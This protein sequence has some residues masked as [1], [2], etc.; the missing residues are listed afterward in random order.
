MRFSFCRICTGVISDRSGGAITTATVTA[1]NDATGVISTTSTNAEGAYRFGNLPVGSYTL[2]ASA[3]G[4]TTA[5]V[6]NFRVQLSTVLTANI[7]LDV[8]TTAT[9]VEV[10]AA[11]AAIDTTTA[12]LQT[13]FETRQT[14]ELP[15]ASSG[16]G[17][18]N[19]SLIGA[20]VASQG[21]VGQGTGP[22]IAGQRPEDNTF[23]LD[24]VSNVNHYSTGPL[25]YVSN[26][27]VAEVSLLQ[28]Q[29]SPEFGGGSGGVFN[30]VV[31]SGTN[32]IHGSI[33]EY[34]QNRNL[35]AV[36]A[37]DWTQGLT[38]LRQP[39][40]RRQLVWIHRQPQRPDSG[41]C[42][43]RPL[44]R[45]LHQQLPHHSVDGSLYLLAT[46]HSKRYKRRHPATDSAAVFCVH[47]RGAGTRA[48]HG[49]TRRGAF[50]GGSVPG[51]V[52][53]R[54]ARVPAPHWS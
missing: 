40:E 2:T 15:S 20:G 45:V 36:D 46:V 18:W 52:P 43:I 24:G 12:Q 17:I 10:S 31:K 8:G 3:K 39:C 30:A 9:S 23:N 19:L 13:T 41:Q 44:R 21:G 35:N 38:S 16:A 32:S 28:N 53:A 1:Q 6:K 11:A 48:C 33:Y 54:Q 37:L 51:R 34:L 50:S 47:V 22:A 27:A 25:V 49:P 14:I 42:R 4:F 29:F 26:E 7:T 5:S